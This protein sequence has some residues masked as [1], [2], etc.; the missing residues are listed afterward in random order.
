M[1]GRRCARLAVVEGED[2]RLEGEWA[3]LEVEYR[4]VLKSSVEFEKSIRNRWREKSKEKN[5]R[6]FELEQRV[7]ELER[8]PEKDG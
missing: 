4:R 1:F 2:S 5:R 8:R 7:A 6:I 3:R